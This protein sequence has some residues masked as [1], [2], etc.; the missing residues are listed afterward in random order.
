MISVLGA[1]GGLCTYTRR[2]HVRVSKAFISAWG[3]RRS[4]CEAR[5]CFQYDIR[6]Y[7]FTHP[8]RFRRCHVDN[9]SF[10]F[11]LVPCPSSHHNPT[12]SVPF[13]PP[14][15]P[16]PGPGGGVRGELMHE[17]GQQE[18]MFLAN[19]QRV[20]IYVQPKPLNL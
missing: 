10:F 6:I 19:P 20:D 9:A 15:L 5:A 3:E 2:F 1:G 11:S 16:S 13:F 17:K 12:T 8:I 14:P 7:H 4:F 18:N